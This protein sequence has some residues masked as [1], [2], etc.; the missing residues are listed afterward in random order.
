MTAEFAVVLPAVV[1]VLALCVGAVNVVAQQVQLTSLASSAARMLARG[2]DSATMHA[3]VVG[4]A[5]GTVVTDAP[6]GDFVCVSLARPARFGPVDLGTLVLNAR[7]CALGAQPL[8][9][10]APE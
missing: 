2:D 10:G 4:A 1:F 7:A 8:P 9:G 6:D 3:R 5:A